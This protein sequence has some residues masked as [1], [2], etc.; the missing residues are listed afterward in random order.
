MEPGDLLTRP[1]T[2]SLAAEMFK[3]DVSI[4][5]H[6][7]GP[8]TL[9]AAFRLVRKIEEAGMYRAR[10]ARRGSMRRAQ[11]VVIRARRD[12]EIAAERTAGLAKITDL[13]LARRIARRIGRK[14]V[15]HAE[16]AAAAADMAACIMAELRVLEHRIAIAAPTIADQLPS[17]L[18]SIRAKV[19]AAASRAGAR[20]RRQNPK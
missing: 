9:G 4:F 3:T 8:L 18:A 7:T 10:A 11:A 5:D 13:G 14:A 17:R 12:A 1:I 15:S 6:H 20:N 16:V 2:A 19:A